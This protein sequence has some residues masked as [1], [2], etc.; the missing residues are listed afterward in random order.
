MF[1]KHRHQQVRTEGFGHTRLGD[2]CT[3]HTIEILSCTLGRLIYIKLGFAPLLPRTC[4]PSMFQKAW[5]TLC[6]THIFKKS[7]GMS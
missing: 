5:K 4:P 3:E 6:K 1:S 2:G 7:I